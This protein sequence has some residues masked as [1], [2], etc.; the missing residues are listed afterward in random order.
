MEVLPVPPLAIG[1]VPVTPLVKLI[2]SSVPPSVKFPELVTVPVRVSP[3][4]VPV[5]PTLVTDPLLAET[6]S[7]A[8]PPELTASTCPAD[9]KAVRFVPPLAIARVPPKVIVPAVVIGPPDEV[10]PVLPVLNATLVT[11]PAPAAAKDNFPLP[12]VLKNVPAEPSPSGSS[13][14]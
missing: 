4:T 10:R 11:E 14:L 5:P 9:P 3:L 8:E 7:K 6:Y 1:S 12:S 2:S 13:K